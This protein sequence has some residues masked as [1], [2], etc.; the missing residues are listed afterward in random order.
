MLVA[1]RSLSIILSETESNI[2]LLVESGALPKA[3]KGK[4]DVAKCISAYIEHQLASHEV[5]DTETAIEEK[6][7]ER[8]QW[9][10]SYEEMRAGLME[11]KFHRNEDSMSVLS[12]CMGN[13]RSRAL[14][15]PSA[16]AR[17]LCGFKNSAEIEEILMDSMESALFELRPYDADLINLRCRDYLFGPKKTEETEEIYDDE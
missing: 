9:L 11:G 6:R 13:F 3:I 7:I 8:T 15:I 12:Q 14:A 16:H 5:S 4:F 17:L 2:R 10:A 1:I